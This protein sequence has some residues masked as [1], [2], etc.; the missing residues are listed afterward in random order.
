VVQGED[1]YPLSPRQG[2]FPLRPRWQRRTSPR[3]CESG[4]S[5]LHQRM[6]PECSLRRSGKNVDG[7][8]GRGPMTRGRIGRYAGQSF[9]EDKK[10]EER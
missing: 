9:K 7:S 4:Q 2:R 6:W 5:P 3:V 10:G 8:A 1:A